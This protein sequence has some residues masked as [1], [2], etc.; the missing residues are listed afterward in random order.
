MITANGIIELIL[1][2]QQEAIE[3]GIQANSI[4]IDEK[5]RYVKPFNLIDARPDGCRSIATFKPMIVGLEIDIKKL[6]DNIDFVVFQADKTYN[7]K[8]TEQIRKETLQD[9]LSFLWGCNYGQLDRVIDAFKEKY[10]VEDD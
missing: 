10:E 6:P 9:V 7:D 1:K 5:L 3:R 8:L 4:I 2:A